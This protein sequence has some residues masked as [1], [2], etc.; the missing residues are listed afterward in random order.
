M[1]KENN[2]PEPSESTSIDGKPETTRR[3]SQILALSIVAG[4]SMGIDATALAQ[5]RNE[6]GADFKIRSRSPAIDAIIQEAQAKLEA[7]IPLPTP[8]YDRDGNTYDR[9]YDRTYDRQHE[10]DRVYDRGVF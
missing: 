7:G 4:G 1:T 2:L 10:Y 9:A 5:L 3:L 8:N 6:T